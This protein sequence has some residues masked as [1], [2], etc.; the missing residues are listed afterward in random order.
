MSEVLFL[1]YS[2]NC[3][4]TGVRYKSKG[5]AIRD[6]SYMPYDERRIKSGFNFGYGTIQ[7]LKRFARF[8]NAEILNSSEFYGI[9]DGIKLSESE[10]SKHYS[11]IREMTR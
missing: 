6:G 5:E 2:H 4:C 10:L 8:N 1:V 7:D 9:L 3:G 11:F